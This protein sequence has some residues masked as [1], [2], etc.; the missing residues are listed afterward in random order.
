ME[1]GWESLDSGAQVWQVSGQFL[2][3]DYCRI[4]RAVPLSDPYDRPVECSGK[5]ELQE[6]HGVCFAC[7]GNSTYVDELAF[8]R[9]LDYQG[10]EHGGVITPRVSSSGPQLM[11]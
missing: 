7:A 9:K 8:G 1:P 2:E 6:T 5:R 3:H 10:Q 11:E 4:Q